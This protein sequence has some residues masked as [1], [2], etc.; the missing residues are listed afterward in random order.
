MKLR[1]LNPRVYKFFLLDRCPKYTSIEREELPIAKEIEEIEEGSNAWLESYYIE[2][3]KR[4]IG[5]M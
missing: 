5:Y 2:R 1:G 4:R 3:K